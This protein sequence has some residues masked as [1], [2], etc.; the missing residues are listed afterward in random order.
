L[1]HLHC[2]P[3][4]EGQVNNNV[5]VALAVALSAVVVELGHGL[6]PTPLRIGIAGIDG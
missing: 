2:L 5:A 3:V 1:L 4:V 6:V